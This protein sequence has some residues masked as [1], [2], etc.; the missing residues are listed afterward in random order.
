MLALQPTHYTVTMSQIFLKFMIGLS[1]AK[2]FSIGFGVFFKTEVFKNSAVYFVFVMVSS[3][4]S[5]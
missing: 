1:E 3:I 5:A 2:Y 4:G